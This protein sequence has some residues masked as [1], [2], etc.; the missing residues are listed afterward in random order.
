MASTIK[1]IQYFD[2]AIAKKMTFTSRKCCL[3]EPKNY[4]KLLFLHILL[5]LSS[6]LAL[7]QTIVFV[8]FSSVLIHNFLEKLFKDALIIDFSH[9]FLN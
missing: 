8:S 7:Y 5:Q 4:G 6:L 9:P 1:V 3:R 2:V